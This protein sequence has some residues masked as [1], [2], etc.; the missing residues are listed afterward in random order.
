MPA[1]GE[2]G[3]RTGTRRGTSAKPTLVLA[4]S[5]LRRRFFLP[6]S[7]NCSE[8]IPNRSSWSVGVAAA[9]MRH[10]LEEMASSVG[11]EFNTTDL[12]WFCHKHR[13]HLLLW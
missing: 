11:S 6:K 4:A 8:R 13:F 12:C 3:S 2:P 5:A 1:H 10:E 9:V 7:P